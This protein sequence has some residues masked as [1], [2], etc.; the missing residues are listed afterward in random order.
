M[1][2]IPILASSYTHNITLVWCL[3]DEFV[4][5]NIMVGTCIWTKVT[6]STAVLGGIFQLVLLPATAALTSLSAIHSGLMI[7]KLLDMEPIGSRCSLIYMSDFVSIELLD[8]LI[9]NG[10]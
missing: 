9:L 7:L 3:L 10:S 2:L 5:G 6:P 4:V 8:L 1:T